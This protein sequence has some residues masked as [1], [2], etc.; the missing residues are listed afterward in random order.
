MSFPAQAK[1]YEYS[2]PGTNSDVVSR[3]N[4]AVDYGVRPSLCG[5]LV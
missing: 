3:E 2:G 1:L 5:E 4:A